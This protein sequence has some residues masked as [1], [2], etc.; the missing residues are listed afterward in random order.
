MSIHVEPSGAGLRVRIDTVT[1][2]EPAVLQKL[3]DCRQSAWACPS[4]ECTKIGAMDERCAD[5]CVFLTLQPRSV[6]PLSA[7]GIEECLRYMLHE[8]AEPR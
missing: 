4:G 7:S 3:R 8:F 1:G 6:E 2:Q 5:G